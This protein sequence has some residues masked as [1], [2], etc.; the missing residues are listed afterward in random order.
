MESGLALLSAERDKYQ[1]AQAPSKCGPR[2]EWSDIHFEIKKID[3]RTGHIFYNEQRLKTL[4]I[5]SLFFL[6]TFLLID[7]LVVESAL[8]RVS[9]TS[10]CQPPLPKVI[11]SATSTPTI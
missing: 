7:T 10:P 1:E 6:S 8:H 11:E 5:L 3:K 4:G 9:P 2:M